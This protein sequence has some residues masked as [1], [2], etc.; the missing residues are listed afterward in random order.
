MTIILRFFPNGE[1]TQGVDTSKKRKSHQHQKP[2][3]STVR[4]S[5]A[6][7]HTYLT[8]YAFDDNGEPINYYTPGQQFRNKRKGIYTYL[9]EDSKGH[10]FAYEA[11]TYVLP[12]VIINEP[13]GVLIARGEMTPLVYQSVE[14]SPQPQKP[15]RKRLDTMTGNMARNIRNAVYLLE[16]TY[17]KDNLSFLTL[18]LPNLSQEDL[19][20][21]CDKWDYMVDQIL[22][23][24]RKRAE[25]YDLE[26]E[27]VYCTEIQPKRLEQRKEYAPHLHIVFRGRNG[28]KAPWI[29]TPKQIRKSWASII[30]SVVH[31]REFQQSALENLQRIKKSAARYLSKYLSK[32]KCRNPNSDTEEYEVKLRTQ[33]GG[34][35]RKLARLLK[36]CT[37][38]ISSSSNDGELAVYITSQMDNL[39]DAGL[40][41]YYKQGFITLSKCSVSGVERVLKVGSGCLATPT[42]EGGLGK[43]AEYFYQESYLH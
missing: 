14:S 37:S 5:V 1:F 42:H 13:I 43:I 40:I 35:A 11:C 6:E 2:N 26:L 31:H 22:K 30:A 24:L 9:C 3:L 34:M 18:T 39:L 7:K 12:D 8:D 19:S 21:V 38:R 36:K 10:H 29:V 4:A 28:R 32:G 33:W 15:S 17:G 23:G 27:Y 16:K 41:K 25:K 20:K